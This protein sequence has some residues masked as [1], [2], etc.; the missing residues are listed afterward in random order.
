MLG[1]SWHFSDGSVE[2]NASNAFL[3]FEGSVPVEVSSRSQI[4]FD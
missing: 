4:R 1:D 2:I 3:A